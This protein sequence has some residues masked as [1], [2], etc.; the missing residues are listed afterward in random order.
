MINGQ[1]IM[2]TVGGRDYFLSYNR[3]PW[4]REA[5]IKDVLNVQMCGDE[6]I[7]WPALDVDLEIES[8]RHPE[9]YPLLIKRNP[10]EFVNA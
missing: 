2:I 5:S 6:A 4:M 9:R 7:E 8:L 10:T 3:I 1:G